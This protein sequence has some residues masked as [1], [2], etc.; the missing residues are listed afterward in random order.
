MGL[1]IKDIFE[2]KLLKNVKIVAG[3]DGM[4]NEITWVN[5]MEILDAPNSIQSGELLVTT[6]YNLDAKEHHTNLIM[7]LKK[8]GVSGLAIQPGY[9]INSIPKHILEQAD[10][11]G[12]PIL[13]FP[14]ELTFSEIL[15]VLIRKINTKKKDGI[16]SSDLHKEAH[17]FFEQVSTDFSAEIICEENDNIAHLL[18]IKSVGYSPNNEQKWDDGLAQIRSFLLADAVQCH[19]KNMGNGNAAFLLTFP[20]HK[21][22]QSIFYELNIQLT[23]LS[24]QQG[25]NYYIGADT[26]HTLD[27]LGQTLR[28]IVSALDVLKSIKARRGLCTYEHIP[29]LKMFGTL[30]HTEHSIVL[31]NQAFQILL[32]YDRINKTNYVHTL[33]I[34]LAECCNASHTAKRLFIHRHTLLNRLNKITELSGIN[35]DDY[36]ARIYVSTTMLFH[37]FFSY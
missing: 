16:F 20:K 9:Y 21:A 7:N 31:E 29:Y 30:H 25:V 3:F 24:E 11:Y 32:N 4:T 6:G 18:L 10:Y 33:R 8:R 27:Q 14:R 34:Y 17:A 5:I 23:H 1:L 35:I 22:V 2:Q 37:D 19:S 28:H 13:E 36:Y 26:L 15:R 12:F